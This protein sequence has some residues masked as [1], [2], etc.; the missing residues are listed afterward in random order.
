MPEFV[1]ESLDLGTFHGLEA[2]NSEQ[3]GQEQTKGLR[4]VMVAA[5]AGF[6]VQEPD[7]AFRCNEAT[8]APIIPFR[9]VFYK[10]GPRRR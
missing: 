6:M 8:H 10:I 7:C 4:V 1:L 5:T 9:Q 2:K 3:R